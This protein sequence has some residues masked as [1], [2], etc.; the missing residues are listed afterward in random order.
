MN[1]RNLCHG[2]TKEAAINILETGFR[3]SPAH[4]TWCGEGIYFY[5]VEAKALWFA[6]RTCRKSSSSTPAIVYADILNIGRNDVVD[7]RTYADAR[8]FQNIVTQLLADKRFTI[9]GVENETE[10]IITLRAL[11]IGYYA[12][13]KRKKLVIGNY[14]QRFQPNDM[15]LINELNIVLGVETIY[16]VKDASILQNIRMMEVN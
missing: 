3:F 16:C 12:K 7:L 4:G 13:Y 8:D 2:T 15:G 6:Q 5:D 1:Y 9:D 14:R 10:R 11:L